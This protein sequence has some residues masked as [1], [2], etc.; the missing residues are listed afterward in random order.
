[1]RIVPN[2]FNVVLDEGAVQFKENEKCT[3]NS[4]NSPMAACLV[5]RGD[6]SSRVS[7]QDIY[8]VIILFLKVVV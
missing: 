8:I 7:L 3:D 4:G 5:N 2:D 1:M 6:T